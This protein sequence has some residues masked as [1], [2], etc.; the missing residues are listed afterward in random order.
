[1]NPIRVALSGALPRCEMDIRTLP[2]LGLNKPE[3]GAA[4]ILGE[5]QLEGKGWQRMPGAAICLG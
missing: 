1:V 4:L 5:N 2:G 3:M